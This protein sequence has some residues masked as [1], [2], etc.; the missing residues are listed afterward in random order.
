MDPSPGAGW[1]T[2]HVVLGGLQR[3]ADGGGAPLRHVLAQPLLHV[4]MELL[5]EEPG[6]WLLNF[7]DVVTVWNLMLLYRRKPVLQTVPGPGPGLW[8]TCVSEEPD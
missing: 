7:R 5:K 1:L 8:D 3:A 2:D 4:P 6:G